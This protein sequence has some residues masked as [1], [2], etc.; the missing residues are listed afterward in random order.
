MLLSGFQDMENTNIPTSKPSAT[1]PRNMVFQGLRRDFGLQGKEKSNTA[2]GR[3][4]RNAPEKLITNE[5][6]HNSAG[7]GN[8]QKLVIK[9]LPRLSTREK[10]KEA[11]YEA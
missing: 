4:S 2:S 1:A 7:D 3:P 11:Y 10:T 5:F 6:R 8:K 9:Y